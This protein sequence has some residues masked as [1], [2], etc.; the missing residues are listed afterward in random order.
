MK[1]TSIPTE[2][3]QTPEVI[4]N[5]GNNLPEL[6]DQSDLSDVSATADETPGA[7]TAT[8]DRLLELLTRVEDA[9]NRLNEMQ[10]SQASSQISK[11]YGNLVAESAPDN[12]PDFL[13]ERRHGFWE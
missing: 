2:T 3:S 12:T 6:Q 10:A 13:A 1:N 4:E 11:T 7:T 8:E 5:A 9:I